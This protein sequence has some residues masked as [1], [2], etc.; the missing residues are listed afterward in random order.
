MSVDKRARVWT[1]E[2]PVGNAFMV[3]GVYG[4][5]SLARLKAKRLRK[6]GLAA[7]VVGYLID[8]D[9]TE[10][11]WVVADDAGLGDV[12][13]VYAYDDRAWSIDTE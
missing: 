5:R 11:G 6:G 2:S 8:R 10:S 9:E 1:V 12:R 4:S 7:V 3:R 13:G